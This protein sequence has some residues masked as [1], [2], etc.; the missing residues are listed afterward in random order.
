MRLF[1]ITSGCGFSFSPTL[2][3]E[4]DNIIRA[5]R[6]LEKE[7]KGFS[8][9]TFYLKREN[10]K[11][12]LPRIRAFRPD[13][14]LVFKGFR[15]P[16]K[17]VNAIQSA[18]YRV[19]VWLVD[20]PYRLKTHYHLVKPYSFVLTQEE[21][22]VPFYRKMGKPSF[23]LPLAVNLE[24]YGPLPSVPQKYRSDICFIGSGF[25]VRILMI[26]KLAPFLRNK[27]F[28]LIGQWW[29]RL[30]S[31]SQLRHCII[32]KPVPPE[33]VLKY[34][35]GAKIVLNI[36][37][38]PN[39]R[40]ENF[41]NLPAITPNN[42]T[43]EIAGCRAFQLTSARKGLS[44][45]YKSNEIVTFNGWKDLRKKLEYYLTHKDERE[46]IAKRAYARTKTHHTYKARLEYLIVLLNRM[47]LLNKRR[48]RK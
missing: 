13:V 16:H 20:D 29:H 36:H 3:D 19:G 8:F 34:Y 35:N 12:L 21:S 38:T 41:K 2:T 47:L 4:D 9:R 44:K 27:D 31:Y 37:R 48:E 33:E 15:F 28:L 45:F 42:R 39:D 23:H 40:H 14:V 10:P 5:F 18:G 30:K 22:C 43:F 25:P 24:K 26:D 11:Y 46:A 32:N 17:M 7:R 6:Q 1:F